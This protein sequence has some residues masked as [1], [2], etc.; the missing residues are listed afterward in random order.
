MDGINDLIAALGTPQL[1]INPRLNAVRSVMVSGGAH[2]EDMFGEV[3]VPRGLVPSLD[4]VSV[5]FLYLV[6]CPYL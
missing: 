4:W 5:S 2:T 1:P 3:L 6:Q